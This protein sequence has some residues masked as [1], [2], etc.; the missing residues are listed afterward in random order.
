MTL[1]PLQEEF[2]K[3]FFERQR[4]IGEKSLEDTTTLAKTNIETILK[5]GLIAPLTMKKMDDILKELKERNDDLKDKN[6]HNQT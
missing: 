5:V 2:F 1:S 3:K 4:E 6:D